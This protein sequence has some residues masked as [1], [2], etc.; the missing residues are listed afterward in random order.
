MRKAALAALCAFVVSALAAIGLI[1]AYLLDA[2][3]AVSGILLFIALGGFGAALALVANGVLPVER[4]EEERLPLASPKPE[5]RSAVEMLADDRLLGRRHLVGAAV[6]ALAAL[7][8][9]SLFPIASLRLREITAPGVTRWRR[10][11]RVVRPDGSP[12][13]AVDVAFGTM[14]T[15][16]PEGAVGDP[17]SQTILLRVTPWLLQLPQGR[18]AW[19]PEGCVA[20]S[21]VCTHAGCAVALYRRSTQQLRCPCHQSTFDVLRGAVPVYGPAARSLPQLPLAI[22]GAGVLRALDDYAEPIG[23]DFWERA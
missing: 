20:F 23:P 18:E 8:A 7:S 12:V 3:L 14:L 2:P 4:C 5:R 11:S 10:G 13:R 6:G 15:V 17:A 21:K 19:A 22:D 1:A 9:A 16:F